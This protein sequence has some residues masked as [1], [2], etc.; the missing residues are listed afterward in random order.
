MN[1]RAVLFATATVSAAAAAQAASWTAVP[2]APD[3]AIDLA[4]LHLERSRVTVWV[5][6]WG[7]PPFA[8]ELTV[9]RI[10]PVRVNRSA[11]RTEFDCSNR[12]MRTLATHA[13]DGAGSPVYM[14]SVP[15]PVR[16]VEGQEL[17][18]T[19]DAVCEAA[20]AGGRL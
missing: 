8:P 4:S 11:L 18:W 16:P 2:G 3:V 9:H 13:Y 19:Y 10:G 14:S 12:T 5:R 20:R 15:G 17:E 6:W 1:L 7:R